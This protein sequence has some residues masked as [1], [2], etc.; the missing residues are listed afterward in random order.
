MSKYRKL[1][2][3]VEQ[4][5]QNQL[6]K[7]KAVLVD[8]ENPNLRIEIEFRNGKLST[9]IIEKIEAVKEVELNNIDYN[10]N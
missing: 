2:Q 10:E 9:T 5:E 1:K 4:L 6:N 8:A 7:S 3:R